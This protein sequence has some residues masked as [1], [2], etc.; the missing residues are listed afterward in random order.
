MELV[1]GRIGVG[2]EISAIGAGGSSFVWN[3]GEEELGHW[4]GGRVLGFCLLLV[5]YCNS[6]KQE[7]LLF[8]EDFILKEEMVCSG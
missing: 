6:I 2:I 1:L 5:R 8:S 4:G 7:G 3:Q